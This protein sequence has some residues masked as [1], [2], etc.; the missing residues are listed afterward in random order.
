MIDNSIL[1]FPIYKKRIVDSQEILKSYEILSDKL[2]SENPQGWGYSWA[3]VCGSWNSL[4]LCDN[5]I[6][7]VEKFSHLKLHID[8]CV[9]E[10]LNQ[11]DFNFNSQYF[12]ERHVWLN[13]TDKD[14]YQETH[15]HVSLP[16]ISGT[17]YI[18]SPK[19]YGNF[20]F[21]NP[22]YNLEREKNLS[23]FKEK[24]EVDL[25]AGD[26]ILFPSNAKH[27]VMKNPKNK[28]RYS[29][30]FNYVIYEKY[31]NI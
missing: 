19:Q 17:F 31:E 3:E 18:S 1:S 28:N 10:Y 27:G 14:G 29:I 26:L 23:I 24:I 25:E 9:R 30:S 16:T 11:L 7:Y 5:I 21:E 20:Y 12:K 2:V 6:Q 4:F 22:Y 8:N 13:A 15:D